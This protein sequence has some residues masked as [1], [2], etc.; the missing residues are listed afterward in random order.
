MR[1]QKHLFLNLYEFR[2]FNSSEQGTAMPFGNF[3]CAPLFAVPYVFA[4][5]LIFLRNKRF[6]V[7]LR[8][9]VI[10]LLVLIEEPN[11]L[12]I[13]SLAVAPEL[14]RF[15]IASYILHYAERAAKRLDKEYLELSVL[16]KNLAA[17]NLYKKNGFSQKEERK[18]TLILAKKVRKDS[19]TSLKFEVFVRKS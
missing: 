19:T 4:A 18:R 9:R 12:H 7:K 1:N 2:F 16:K 15:G 3:K 14:R 6:F 10:G 11:A 5:E 8:N 13:S 17:R